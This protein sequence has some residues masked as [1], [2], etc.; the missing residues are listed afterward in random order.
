M[1]DERKMRTFEYYCSHIAIQFE[2]LYILGDLFEYWIGKDIQSQHQERVFSALA[3]ASKDSKIM[4][5]HGNREIL[6]P[7]LILEQ[8]GVTV[9]SDY[10]TI[11][12]FNNKGMVCHG[13]RLCTQ[14]KGAQLIRYASDKKLL[15]VITSLPIPIRLWIL[16]K[17]RNPNRPSPT[18]NDCIDMDLIFQHI[19]Y[20]KCQWFFH[21]H[22]H[23]P[24]IKCIQVEGHA[25]N[26][27]SLPSW[28]SDPYHTIIES[29]GSVTSE[30]INC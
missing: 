18:S 16:K 12:I 4:F 19:K 2:H 28:D 1:K 29:D 20:N 21:G 11:P 10:T 7:N 8:C 14:D 9:L 6:L 22:T 17:L 23:F 24:E 5:V 15:S 27:I 25:F 13:D 26:Y 3:K 30:K